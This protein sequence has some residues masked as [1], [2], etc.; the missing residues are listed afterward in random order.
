MIERREFSGCMKGKNLR[1][2]DEDKRSPSTQ[3]RAGFVLL[4]HF[5]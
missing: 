3:T 4:E 1:Y 5:S 2:V